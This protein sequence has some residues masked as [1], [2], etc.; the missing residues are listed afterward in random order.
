MRF[1][2]QKAT[3]VQWCLWR[4]AAE[5]LRRSPALPPMFFRT[6]RRT[7]VELVLS[8]APRISSWSESAPFLVRESVFELTVEGRIHSRATAATRPPRARASR[9][10][11]PASAFAFRDSL[12]ELRAKLAEPSSSSTAAAAAV[13]ESRAEALR[14]REAAVQSKKSCTGAR[15]TCRSG[16]GSDA[17]PVPLERVELTVRTDDTHAFEAR[18]VLDVGASE[19]LRCS[20]LL[21]LH[22]PA[23]GAPIRVQLRAAVLTRPLPLPL[24]VAAALPSPS[25]SANAEQTSG[26]ED[27]FVRWPLPEALAYTQ[28]QYIPDNTGDDPMRA[29]SG[30]AV[31][32]SLA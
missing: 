25:S 11:A 18:R 17:A 8:P 4:A 6:V 1:S 24:G 15:R 31:I 28:L 32:N 19:Y 23:P 14:T 9:I 5:L 10:A 21:P 30:M 3:H 26:E 29:V 7:S 20:V 22:R 16:Y 2:L 12:L 13:S 27:E